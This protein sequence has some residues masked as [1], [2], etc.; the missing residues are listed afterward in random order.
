MTPEKM[1]IIEKYLTVEL[2]N[3]LWIFINYE[4]MS[5]DKIILIGQRMSAEEVLKIW[6]ERL[7]EMSISDL[8]IELF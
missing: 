7:T 3:V 5:L 2:I 4:N 6:V 8:Q 1:H